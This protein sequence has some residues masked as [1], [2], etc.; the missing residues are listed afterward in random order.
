[1][2]I[3]EINVAVPADS[4]QMRR[5]AE[6]GSLHVPDVKAQDEF[7]LL[8]DNAWSRTM[9]FVPLRGRAGTMGSLTA[10]RAE[11][12]P[13]TDAQIRLLESFADQ[14]VIALENV[15]LFHELEARN[16]ALREALEHQTATA[17]MLGIIS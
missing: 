7:P 14:A 9:A 4:E 1:G 12:R 10:R 17:E 6:Q 15:R 3:Q 2:P 16:A 11:V 5:M 13:F 8:R